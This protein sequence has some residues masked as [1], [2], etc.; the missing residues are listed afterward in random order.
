MTLA[1]YSLTAFTVLN[2]ARIVAYCPQI[3]CVYRDRRGAASVSMMTWGMFF[4]ANIATVSYALTVSGD[5]IVAGVFAANAL[6][7][8]T[9]FVL[10]LR[11]RVAHSW[12]K[13]RRA[14][15]SHARSVGASTPSVIAV[16]LASVR[17]RLEDRVTAHHRGEN[18][19]DALE[20]KINRDCEAYRCGRLY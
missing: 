12:R 10:I 18:W 14:G 8:V 13:R 15:H 5:R 7:C 3:V 9:I 19:S 20:R 1:D 17:H 6:A 4:S 16:A 2:G 11:K